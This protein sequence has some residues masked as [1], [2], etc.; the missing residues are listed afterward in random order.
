MKYWIRNILT[1]LPFRLAAF[2]CILKDFFRSCSACS[3][4]KGMIQCSVV[5]W[6]K[7]QLRIFQKSYNS[8]IPLFLL[9]QNT[10]IYWKNTNST[11]Y[12]NSPYIGWREKNGAGLGFYHMKKVVRDLGFNLCFYSS[13]FRGRRITEIGWRCTRVPKADAPVICSVACS[14]I[15]ILCRLFLR[16]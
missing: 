8:S 6:S 7:I 15:P 10:A 2:C 4:L 1:K 9:G 5:T 16:A 14:C 13:S 3:Y 11:D 12:S